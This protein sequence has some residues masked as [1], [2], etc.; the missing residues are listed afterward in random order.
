MAYLLA[1]LALIVVAGA[2]AY[3]LMPEQLS[4]R[5]DVYRVCRDFT[6]AKLK[7]PATAVFPNLKDLERLRDY[8]FKKDDGRAYE[9]LGYVDSENSFGAMLRTDFSCAVERR[10]RSWVGSS[11]LT[12]RD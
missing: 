2:V 4:V 1:G 7:A 10:G 6:A 5:A 11:T 12:P 3:R 8:G 9:L